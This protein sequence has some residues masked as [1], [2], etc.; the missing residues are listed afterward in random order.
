MQK[1]YKPIAQITVLKRGND[2][3]YPCLVVGYQKY[4]PYKVNQEQFSMLLL[5]ENP[6]T[7]ITYQDPF[8]A[9][10]TDNDSLSQVHFTYY[11]EFSAGH[12]SLG[13]VADI[14]GN[15]YD[16][17]NNNLV[18]DAKV[19]ISELTAEYAK[20]TFSGTVFDS[21]YTTGTKR[22]SI[23]NGEFYLERVEQ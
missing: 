11:D 18:A 19:T 2:G 10:N 20:G 16:P 12:L 14:N 15:V 17:Y 4:D 23:T 7:N 5:S 9:V 6:I 21:V 1:D 8:K 13:T 22:V 3:L